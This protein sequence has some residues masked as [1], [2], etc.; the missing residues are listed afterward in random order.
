MAGHLPT[1]IDVH[2]A[3]A[4]GLRAIE[5]LGPGV[6]I[7]AATSRD[8]PAVHAAVMPQT[9]KMPMIKLPGMNKLMGHLM[10]GIVINPALRTTAQ[11]LE[12]MQLAHQHVR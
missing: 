12:N 2:D 4:A 3:I 6:A 5:H 7:P 8:E 1:G 9:L 11:A 10:A